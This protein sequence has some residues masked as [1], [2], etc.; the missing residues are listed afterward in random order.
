LY[1]ACW[2]CYQPQGVCRVADT[3]HEER[4]CQYPDVVMPVCYGVYHRVGGTKWLEQHFGRV[5]RSELEYML[6]LGEVG[7]LEGNLCIQA[8]QV[9]AQAFSEFG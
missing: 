7:S 4:L 9:A 6:W 8:T 2:M 5:F 1:V 3:E